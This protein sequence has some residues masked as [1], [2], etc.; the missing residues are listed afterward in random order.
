MNDPVR[1]EK[2]IDYVERW[3]SLVRA[4]ED[5]GHRLDPMHGRADHWAGDRA[6]RFRRMTARPGAADALIDLIRPL[7][8]PESSVLDVGAGTGRHVLPLAHLAAKVTA[9]EPSAAMRTQ[10]EEVV[11]ENGLRNV[12]IIAAEWPGARVEPA[13]LV[14]CSHVAYFVAEIEPFLREID[15][16]N[17]GRA[18]VVLRHTQREVAI[19]DLFQRIWNE[20]RCPEPSFSDLYGVACQL[21]LYPNVTTIP[22]TVPIGFETIEDAISMVRADLLNPS[23]ADVERVIHD[24]LEERMVRRDGKLRF[25][26]PPTFAGALWWEGKS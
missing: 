2:P 25:A 7:I 5:Q 24:Y 10:L 15:R 3:R 11:R 1:F 20:P 26:V 16:V 21:G 12:E 4:R 6:A 8:G 19:L 22:F 23:G 18:V 14:V 17:L 9:V 13:D